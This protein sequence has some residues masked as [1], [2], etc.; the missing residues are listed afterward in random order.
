MASLI[1]MD[2]ISLIHYLFRE[3]G[4]SLYFKSYAMEFLMKPPEKHGVNMQRKIDSR[5]IW[6]H[7]KEKN[8][9]VLSQPYYAGIQITSYDGHL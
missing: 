8:P 3:F 9:T 5:I 6:Y 1:K 4:V 7:S 2:E